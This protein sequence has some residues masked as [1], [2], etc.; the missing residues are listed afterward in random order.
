M[1]SA[2]Y[3]SKRSPSPTS[4]KPV[5]TLIAQLEILTTAT[6]YVALGPI[7]PASRITE[8]SIT[9]RNAAAGRIDIAPVW[10][11]A[12]RAADVAHAQGEALVRS[13][14]ITVNGIA[15]LT[16]G[17]AANTGLHATWSIN[18]V[19]NPHQRWLI[20]AVTHSSTLTLSITIALAYEL[21]LR[22]PVAANHAQRV[23]L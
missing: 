1:H 4:S 3:P 7:P 12:G 5:P 2:Y 14:E 16:A 15:A 21:P 6:D 11:N 13:S 10:H 20:I 9:A 22:T 19:T 18:H 17:V 8:I 23:G